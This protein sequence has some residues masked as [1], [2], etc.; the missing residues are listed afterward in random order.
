MKH[1]L[2][3]KQEKRFW[4]FIFMDDF[5]FYDTYISELPEEAQ[6]RFFQ[7]TPEFFS[8]ILNESEPVDLATDPIYKKIKQQI[9]N[10]KKSDK[11]SEN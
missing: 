2:S 7:E 11:A 5:Q 10:L 3:R 8:D 4:E 9:K 1:N 6:E